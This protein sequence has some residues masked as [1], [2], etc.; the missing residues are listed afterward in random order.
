MV[1][2]W[3][4]VGVAVSEWGAPGASVASVTSTAKVCVKLVAWLP[5]AAGN[6]YV[7]QVLIVRVAVLR[8][9]VVRG[10]LE[11][12]CPCGPANLK[13]RGVRPAVNLERLDVVQGVAVLRR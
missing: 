5:R 12:Q 13:E 10:I 4:V 8:I 11:D 3:V 2:V 9:L 1:A 7:H 6:L